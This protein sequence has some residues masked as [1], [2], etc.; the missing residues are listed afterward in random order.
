MTNIEAWF[1]KNDG[2]GNFTRSPRHFPYTLIGVSG[3]CGTIVYCSKLLKYLF[4][5]DRQVP[6]NVGLL[7]RY[8]LPNRND[9]GWMRQLVGKRKLLFFGDLDPVDLLVF[10]WLRRRLRGVWLEHLGIN[11]ALLAAVGFE[12]ADSVPS[13][14]TIRL[15]GS[16]KKAM[17]V[18]AKAFPD[19]AEIVGEKC[20]ALLARG[21]KL[22]I[23]AILSLNAAIRDALFAALK[24]H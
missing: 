24:V 10:A 16:E 13:G 9:L 23:E 1:A 20:A 6:S 11:D 8:G 22:E 19:F 14:R 12:P 3:P 17:Q 4:L 2:D 21:R 5:D 18:L 7:Q 15:R